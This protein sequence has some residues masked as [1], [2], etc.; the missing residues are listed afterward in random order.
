MTLPVLGIQAQPLHPAAT[1]RGETTCGPNRIMLAKIR[2][3]R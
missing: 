3:R 1:R 2:V